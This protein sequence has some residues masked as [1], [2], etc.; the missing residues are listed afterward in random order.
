VLK[1]LA[2]IALLLADGS[3]RLCIYCKQKIGVRLYKAGIKNAA[4]LLVNTKTPLL[5]AIFQ[6]FLHKAQDEI[7]E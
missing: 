3:V 2:T 1:A 5:R 7:P 4:V 6:Q